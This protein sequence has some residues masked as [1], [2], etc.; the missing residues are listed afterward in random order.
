MTYKSLWQPWPGGHKHKFIIFAR[1]LLYPNLVLLLI[2][3]FDIKRRNQLHLWLKTP[4]G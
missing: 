3:H 2:A 1:E 4:S